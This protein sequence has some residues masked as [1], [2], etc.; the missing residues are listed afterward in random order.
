LKLLSQLSILN[1]LSTGSAGK[2]TLQTGVYAA[3]VNINAFVLRNSIYSY[4]I[5]YALL[6]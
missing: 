4:G 2:F 3:F 6:F 1:N 5:L